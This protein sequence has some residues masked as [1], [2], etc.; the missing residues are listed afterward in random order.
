MNI[1]SQ[2]VQISRTVSVTNCDTIR[3]NDYL[4]DTGRII[5]YNLFIIDQ[6]L[7]DCVNSTLPSSSMSSLLE[8]ALHP[9]ESE[10][11]P[12]KDQSSIQELD[13]PALCVQALDL[14]KQF[15]RRLGG[16]ESSPERM[17]Q[18]TRILAH[19]NY[20]KPGGEPLGAPG[21]RPFG[22]LAR[23]MRFLAGTWQERR[24]N[25]SQ[26]TNAFFAARG[27]WMGSERRTRIP[28]PQHVERLPGRR[29]GSR[30]DSRFRHAV[31]SSPPL[32]ND[33]CAVLI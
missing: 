22:S 9:L 4:L 1:L 6:L 12:A 28:V 24:S 27:A 30:P 11:P 20:F 31:L 16:F 14:V 32:S 33:I 19:S 26:P 13:L 17:G 15:P 25:A 18:T 2:S 29:E 5:M 8:N 23:L 21:L 7:S 10:S 3:Y